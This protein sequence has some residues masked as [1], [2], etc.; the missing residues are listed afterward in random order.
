M[1]FL[2]Q[3][4]IIQVFSYLPYKFIR[5]TASL[6]CK[7]WC[8]AAYDR[9]L[10]RYAK[11]EEFLEITVRNSPKETV[12]NFLQAVNWR[13][14]LFQYIDLS[15]SKTTWETFCEIVHLCTELKILNMAGIKGETSRHPTI[16]ASKIVELN[17]SET[18]ID[19][20]L[21]AFITEHLPMLGILN[22]SGCYKL[23]NVGVEKASF[24]SLRFLAIANCLIDVE[25]IL[26]AINKHDIFAMCTREIELESEDIV[27][28]LESYPDIAEIGI[29]TLC[30]LPQGT[31]SPEALP[32][33]CFY[34]CRARHSTIL[35][36]SQ[37][38]DG[39]WMEL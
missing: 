17:L 23:T 5:A 32:Q 25:G 10:I 22:V 33:V 39:S 12:D 31:V 35:K 11:E 27:R 9:S 26:C 37:A 29:P 24:P 38:I 2:P 34:C 14:R 28:L 4:I 3:S 6:V 20:N 36:T 30:G 21:L 15:C 18:L 13:P 8:Q 16:R 7:A 19:D 1:E